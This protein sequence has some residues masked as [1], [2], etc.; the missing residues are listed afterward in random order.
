MMLVDAPDRNPDPAPICWGS[1]GGRP[2]W[3]RLRHDD[4][5]SD[6][7]PGRRL[8][9]PL[10]GERLEAGA[11]QRRPK[12]RRIVHRVC[13]IRPNAQA[14]SRR[15]GRPDDDGRR[16]SRRPDGAATIGRVRTGLDGAAGWPLSDELGG[17]RPRR[18]GGACAGPKGEPYLRDQR[19]A[20]SA[21][22]R[23]GHRVAGPGRRRSRGKAGCGAEPGS[24][25]P[26]AGERP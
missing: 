2:Q 11:D 9:D 15:Q 21:A 14:L 24:S 12:R 5:R 22:K 8:R 13:R 19:F 18:F 16:R 20:P 4:T 3:R 23:R 25:G 1:A 26:V 10:R 7:W 17:P 6:D